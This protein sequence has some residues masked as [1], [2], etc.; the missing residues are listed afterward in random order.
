MALEKCQMPDR[1]FLFFTYGKISWS[2]L[3]LLKLQT[4]KPRDHYFPVKYSKKCMGNLNDQ[5]GKLQKELQPLS[6]GPL[7]IAPHPLSD[8][9]GK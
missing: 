9:K 1:C 6:P 7:Q 8:S 5:N 2:L 4:F 3:L